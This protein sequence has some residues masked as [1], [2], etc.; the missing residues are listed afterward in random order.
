M[1]FSQQVKLT[2]IKDTKASRAQKKLDISQKAINSAAK[3]TGMKHSA[4]TEAY[5]LSKNPSSAA[6]KNKLSSISEGDSRKAKAIN[7]SF[8]S[9]RRRKK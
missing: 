2:G 6:Y 1:A 8:Q 5:N 9:A 3:S 7:D 4:V